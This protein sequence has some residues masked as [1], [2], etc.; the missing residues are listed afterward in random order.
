MLLKALKFTTILDCTNPKSIVIQS[1]I[2]IGAVE[3]PL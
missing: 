1:G 3:E 2:F